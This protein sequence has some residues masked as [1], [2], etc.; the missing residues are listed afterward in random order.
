MTVEELEQYD[1]A[2]ARIDILKESI[3]RLEKKLEKMNETGYYVSDVV[4]KGKKGK[5]ALGTVRVKGFP[6]KE[7]ERCSKIIERRMGMLNTELEKTEM[8]AEEIERYIGEIDSMEI[9]NI[10][11]LRYVERLT[12]LQVAH[13][14]NEKYGKKSGKYT[15]DSCRHKHDRFFLKKK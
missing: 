13:R 10:L 9:R 15:S 8:Q 11:T 14:M 7:Y 2:L 1:S 5:K 4:T 3:G 12:W 6:N